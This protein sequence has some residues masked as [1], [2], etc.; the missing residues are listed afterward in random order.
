MNIRRILLINLNIYFNHYAMQTS[1]NFEIATSNSTGSQIL[2]KQI[3][4]HTQECT[5][6]HSLRFSAP[7]IW[8]T[9]MKNGSSFPCSL[10]PSTDT[11][12]FTSCLTAHR[13]VETDTLLSPAI[14]KSIYLSLF[15]LPITYT[16]HED[17]TQTKAFITI[18]S[19]NWMHS[20]VQTQFTMMKMNVDVQL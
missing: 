19:L 11:D 12:M 13:F 7:V 16:S 9:V 6:I 14:L 10:K 8:T 2:L 4:K 15:P 3:N 18:H 5:H 20:E 17:A 1:Q